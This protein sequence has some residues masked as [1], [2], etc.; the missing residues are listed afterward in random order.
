M[1]GEEKDLGRGGLAVGRS[2]CDWRHSLQS[3]RR[4]RMT[5]FAVVAS[6]T[7]HD[8][9]V[10]TDKLEELIKTATK[11]NVKWS[12]RDRGRPKLS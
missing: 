7:N 11:V 4:K 5:F 6:A 12:N 1:G 3:F 8:F 2:E 10:S 9:F